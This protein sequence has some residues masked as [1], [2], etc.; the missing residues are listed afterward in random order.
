MD[1]FVNTLDEQKFRSTMRYGMIYV[2]T[3]LGVLDMYP[4]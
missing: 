3:I 4:H 2:L 1:E